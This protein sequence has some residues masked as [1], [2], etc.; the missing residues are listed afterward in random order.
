[1]KD[2]NSIN[3]TTMSVTYLHQNE[4]H[5]SSTLDPDNRDP[6]QINKHLQVQDLIEENYFILIYFICQ[7][8][9]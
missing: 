5:Q 8:V 3:N 7:Q 6:L 2:T 4:T 1:M 9:L